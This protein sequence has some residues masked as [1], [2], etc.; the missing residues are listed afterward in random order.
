MVGLADVTAG[1]IQ[2]VS[3]GL[4][5]FVRRMGGKME[6]KKNLQTTRLIKPIMF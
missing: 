2:S 4:G 3:F 1:L 6:N 5:E